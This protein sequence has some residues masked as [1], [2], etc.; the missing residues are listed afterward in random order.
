M[1]ALEDT[2]IGEAGAVGTER[3][4]PGLRPQPGALGA[5]DSS[6]LAHDLATLGRSPR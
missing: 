3:R 4:G 1:P 6:S 2:D 5:L